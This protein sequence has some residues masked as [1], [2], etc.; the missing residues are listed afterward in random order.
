M[1]WEEGYTMLDN[2]FCRRLAELRIQKGVSARDM[3]L[4]IGQ[5]AGYINN[6][7]NGKNFPSMM[8]FFY[9]C[10]YLGISPEEFFAFE[11]ENPIKSSEIAKSLKSLDDTKLNILSAIIKS[12]EK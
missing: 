5:S 11:T 6:I 10:E 1:K 2:Q 8:G 7:E 3:S 4:S 9:I 12:W